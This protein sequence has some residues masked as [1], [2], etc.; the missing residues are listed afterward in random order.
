VL[1]REAP[2][3]AQGQD[4]PALPRLRLSPRRL[5]LLPSLALAVASGLVLSLSLPPAGIGWLAFLAPIPLLWLLREAGPG[6]GAAVGA[7]FGASYF[8][9]VLYWLLLFGELGWS[10]LVLVSSAFVA[11]FGAL[12]PL[13]S[14]RDRPVLSAI[15]LAALWTLIEWVR[16]AWPLG[17]FGWGQLGSTQTN[18]GALLRLAPITGVWGMSFVVLLVGALL[19][20]ALE[21]A[22]S[23]PGRALTF[24]AVAAALIVGPAA[25]PAG[26]AT[27]PAVRV[28][29]VQVDVRRAAAPDAAAEDRS[30]ARMNA[31]ANEHLA[32]DPPDL[33]VWGEGALDP[34]AF[35]DPATMASVR[36]SIAAV[37]APTLAGAVTDSP[38]GVQRTESVLF[39]G[40]GR[41]VDRY[42]KV[43]LVPF[44][45]Y[46]P[47]RDE[48][49]WISAL[50]QIPVDR[51]PGDRIA[52]VRVSGIPAFGTP[53]CY[54]NSFPAIERSFVRAG[55][56][57]LVL[58]I[59]NA[60]YGRTAASRQH[61]I[62]SQLRA[63]ETDRWV[64]HA[65]VSGVSAFVD[66]AGRVVA[67]TGLFRD[68]ILRHTIRASDRV[69]PYVRLGDWVPA[70]SLVLVLGFAIVPRVRRRSMPP[71][72]ELP[73][74]PRVLVILPTYDERQTIGTVLGRLRALPQ[75]IDVLVV[76]D[77]SPDGTAEVVEAAA[78]ED[79]RIRLVRRPRKAGLASAYWIGFR[80]G[81]E[82]AYDLVVEMD[83]DLSHDPG[84]L[85][86]L[87]E[88]AGR[89][90]LV[91]GSRYVPGGSVSNW[92][93]ARVTLS[94]AGNAYARL[95]LGF[96]LH[97]ATSGFRV[98]RRRLL[99]HLVADPIRSDGYGFQIELAFRAWRDGFA[100][101]E[102]PITFRERE[103]GTSKIS[104]R[105]VVEALWLVSV[106]GL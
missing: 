105:I 11:A 9:A 56:R 58:T 19:L 71:P 54:E 98:Y 94:R 12:A 46:V 34:A 87:L 28:A 62:M 15:G 88:A 60:S 92:S 68:A 40:G 5:G 21:R 64:V 100:V 48:L 25:I 31:A 24:V 80:R 75:H 33:A 6:R 18:E 37:G 29:E 66:P 41:I 20:A 36:R 2:K 73:A 39:D 95:M 4:A 96:G 38:D 55:A 90:D 99:E 102:A 50:R 17:G 97:D 49:S 79:A 86:R 52:A 57:F 89:H 22:R 16:G 26:G 65:A 27:G 81:L 51:V 7:L 70:L 85:P 45:E 101:G 83:S 104:R 67:E 106:W 13:V 32:A 3:P 23:L 14:R 76:D 63:A 42:A 72:G 53:I 78:A 47:W 82:E 61:L 10:A 35:A 8:G 69:T 103:H 93:T 84:E 74:S 91:I 77:G 44:G 43:H 59:N 1:P 30:V